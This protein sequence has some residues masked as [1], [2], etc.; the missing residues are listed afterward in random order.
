[1][2]WLL[3]LGVAP[4]AGLL[5]V[6]SLVFSCDFTGHSS[7]GRFEPW[8]GGRM[9]ANREVEVLHPSYIPRWT[10]DG[11]RI[12][13]T[14]GRGFQYGEPPSASSLPSMKV[15]LGSIYIKGADGG[16]LDRVSDVRGPVEF[17]FSLDL[18]PD[19]SRL[20]HVTSR[21]YDQDHEST[22]RRNFEIEVSSLDSP[23][24]LR[25]TK[26]RNH[27]DR[28]NT[29]PKWSPDGNLVAFVKRDEYREDVA[30]EYLI[31]TVYIVRADGASLRL[32]YS[33]EEHLRQHQPFTPAQIVE[34]PVWSPD[35][36]RLAFKGHYAHLHAS[37]RGE[38]ILHESQY[39]ME[40]DGS[41]LIELL[42]A[43][44]GAGPLVAGPFA[45]SPEGQEITFVRAQHAPPEH[46][47]DLIATALDGSERKIGNFGKD[48]WVWGIANVEWSPSG[49]YILVSPP[50][51]ASGGAA[52]A[53]DANGAGSVQ[54]AGLG[55]YATWSPDGSRIAVLGGFHC[56]PRRVT[57]PTG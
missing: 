25:L 39:I 53:V 12:V 30:E 22:S 24:S 57:T 48:V 55:G 38:T 33:T 9:D 47:I 13:F 34:S 15:Y 27:S 51:S 35:G 41:G 16:R 44:R 42:R 54:L 8:R 19:G 52:Y 7:P 36:R 45:W 20:V 2:G 17:D 32:L 37:D 40:Q 3:V 50:A 11:E 18:S 56:L 5:T 46:G 6:L 26:D 31:D 1:M 28:T 43:D 49:D 4:F 23:E 10:P 21:H 29:Y 14:V